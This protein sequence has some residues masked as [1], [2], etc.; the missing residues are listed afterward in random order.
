MDSM[1]AIIMF[2]CNKKKAIL[3]V[4]YLQKMCKADTEFP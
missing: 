1:A 2:Y 3:E 4:L